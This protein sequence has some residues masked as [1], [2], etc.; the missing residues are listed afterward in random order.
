L[1]FVS[2][3]HAFFFQGGK[4]GKSFSL[5]C[6]DVFSGKKAGQFQSLL[7]LENLPQYAAGRWRFMA[8]KGF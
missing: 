1:K 2:S 7:S 8:V 5:G 6:P 3:A 4:N